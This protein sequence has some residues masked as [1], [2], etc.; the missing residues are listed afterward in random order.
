MQKMQTFTLLSKYGPGGKADD[1][2]MYF[3]IS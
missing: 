1:K 2:L 3:L